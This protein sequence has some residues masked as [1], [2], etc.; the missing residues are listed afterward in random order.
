[1]DLSKASVEDLRTELARREKC[2]TKPK[3]DLILLGAPG[4]GKGTQANKILT[5]Y[6]YCQIST[7]DLLREAVAKKTPTGLKAKKAMDAGELV[8][9]EIVNELLVGAIRSPQCARGVIFDGYPRNEEQALNLDKLLA[10]EGRKLSKVV[11]LEIDE[12]ILEERVVGRRV[13][14]GSGRSYHVKFNPPKVEG[15]DDVTGEP[16]VH[17]SDDTKEALQTRLKV[18]REKTQPVANYYRKHGL[19]GTVKALNTVENVFR[20]L[21]NEFI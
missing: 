21:Q 3:R 19:L 14:P 11:E 18:Y 17:R 16:L 15:L 5:D 13:H 2:E 7:G 6:C 9:D 10:Q 1:M 4:S 20:D 12:A 8:T